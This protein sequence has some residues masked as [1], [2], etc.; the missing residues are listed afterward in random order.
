MLDIFRSALLLAV[1]AMAVEDNCCTLFED[2][3]YAG[4]SVTLCYVDFDIPSYFSSLDR[5]IESIGSFQCG[6]DVEYSFCQPECYSWSCTSGVGPIN[7]GMANVS[8]FKSYV[9][10]EYAKPW[11]PA[12]AREEPPPGTCM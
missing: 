5:G 7:D 3:W 11:K 4:T 1:G 2:A 6:N 9:K 10:L 12:E 8:E